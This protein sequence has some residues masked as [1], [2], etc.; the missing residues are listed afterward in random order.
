MSDDL[1]GQEIRRAFFEVGD[2]VHVIPDVGDAFYEKPLP[3]G[4]VS[5]LVKGQKD[6]GTIVV[7]DRAIWILAYGFVPWRTRRIL[8][9]PF[10]PPDGEQRKAGFRQTATFALVRRLK[11]IKQ[12]FYEES[13]RIGL[14][15]ADVFLIRPRFP[16][17]I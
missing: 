10:G 6:E 1:T 4:T 8:V 14:G 9:V 17:Q 15:Y 11:N 16:S 2:R 13:D 12:G 7:L 3:E 5:A